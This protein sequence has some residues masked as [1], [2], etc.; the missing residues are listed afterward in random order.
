MRNRLQLVTI[1]I[2][3]RYISQSKADQA[4]DTGIRKSS[5]MSVKCHEC[6]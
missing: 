3:K 6:H 1:H 4:I 2:G 5:V